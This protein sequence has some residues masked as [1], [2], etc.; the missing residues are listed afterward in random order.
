[1][2]TTNTSRTR[3][4]KAAQVAEL[5]A[6][7]PR[8][9]EI[10]LM[11]TDPASITVSGVTTTLTGDDPQREAVLLAARHASSNGRPI[12]MRVTTAGRVQRVI[13]TAD[14][15]VVPLD[16]GPARYRQ[17]PGH[18]DSGAPQ[19]PEGTVTAA[20]GV[21]LSLRNVSPAATC[22]LCC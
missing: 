4:K 18:G 14:H 12:R 6:S 16:T 9:P 3:S 1:M 13:V 8:W 20:A 10:A 15:R 17:T 21:G 22:T 11:L 19:D 7:T 2:T 5:D